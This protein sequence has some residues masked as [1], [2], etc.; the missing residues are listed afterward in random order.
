MEPV[1]PP[2]AA[3]AGGRTGMSAARTFGWRA[4]G[5]IVLAGAAGFY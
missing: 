4:L 2:G 1:E 3:G 5:L